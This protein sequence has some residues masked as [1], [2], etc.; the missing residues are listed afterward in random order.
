MRPRAAGGFTCE[1]ARD[2]TRLVLAARG[3]TGTEADDALLVVTELVS[4]ARRH[5]GGVTAFR[6]R[7]LESSAVIEVSDARQDLPVDRPTPAD[8]PGRFGW[9]MINRIA[10][11]VVAEPHGA[12]KT[13]TVVLPAHGRRSRPRPAG[14]G[15]RGGGPDG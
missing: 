3:V 6:I 8:V 13:I 9:L 10:E 1:R 12:G 5:A 7:C 14:A 4:N 15:R 11:R 2:V